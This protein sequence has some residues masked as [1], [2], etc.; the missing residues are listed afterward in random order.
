MNVQCALI[1]EDDRALSST[2][3]VALARHARELKVA[4]TILEARKQLDPPPD[5]VLLDFALP[6]GNADALLEDLNGLQPLPAV[7]A[8]SGVCSTEEAF[9]LACIGVRAFL[10]K[11]FDLDALS[12]AWRHALTD[13]PD[14]GLSVRQA[15]GKMPLRD[16]EASVRRN[17][18][19]QALALANGSRRNA[20]ALLR[21]SRQLLQ[22]MLKAQ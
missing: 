21:I 14:I 2:L 8:M 17:M 11:P 22:H 4:T 12:R 9:R 20:A 1:I 19:V 5:V 10:Q 3:Q 15:V 13:P 18:L 16:L 6:D 7:I